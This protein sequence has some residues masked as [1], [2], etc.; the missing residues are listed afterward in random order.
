MEK[1]SFGWLSTLLVFVTL[2]GCCL[3]D[4]VVRPRKAT[5]LSQLVEQESA[6]VSPLALELLFVGLLLVPP[7]AC[8][9]IIAY[10]KRKRRSRHEAVVDQVEFGYDWEAKKN[11]RPS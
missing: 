3:A 6:E 4:D 2:A 10:V 7:I 5:D 8:F 1:R 11:D 9:G